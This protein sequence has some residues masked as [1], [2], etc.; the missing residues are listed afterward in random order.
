LSQFDQVL[1]LLRKGNNRLEIRR[2][3]GISARLLD[4]II[5]SGPGV[6]EQWNAARFQQLRQKNRG[7]FIQALA[8]H[9]GWPIEAVRKLP[10]TR[11]SWLKEHDFPWLIDHIP[12]LWKD[13]L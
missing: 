11:F 2:H 9:P 6:V 12:A 8:K 10:G 1:D 3:T 7:R 13:Q 4:L 5:C